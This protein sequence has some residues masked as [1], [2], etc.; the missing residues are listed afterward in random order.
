MA[1]FRVETGTTIAD[2][3]NDGTEATEMSL[4]VTLRAEGKVIIDLPDVSVPAVSVV[5]KE[6]SNVTGA[7][8]RRFAWSTDRVLL[9][10][11]Q[12]EWGA[13]STRI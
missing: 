9:A 6:T 1:A 3:T 13:V 10:D 2:L 4:L 7:W 11:I 12:A 8:L 5:S